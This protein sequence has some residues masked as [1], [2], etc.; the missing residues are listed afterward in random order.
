M[1]KPKPT[2]WKEREEG[3]SDRFNQSPPY[4]LV[5]P[6]LSFSRRPFGKVPCNS[7]DKRPVKILRRTLAAVLPVSISL[8]AFVL[9]GRPTVP[10]VTEPAVIVHGTIG[11]EVRYPIPWH[12]GVPPL[13]STQVDTDG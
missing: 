7:Y 1:L 3:Q 11:L 9:Q 6:S 10:P 2:G 5:P 8:W 12:A 4:N 13:E